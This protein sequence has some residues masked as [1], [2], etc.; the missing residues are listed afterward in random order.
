MIINLLLHIAPALHGASFAPHAPRSPSQC[1]C[2]VS[3]SYHPG[4]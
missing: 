1:A 3:W 2:Q 4:A